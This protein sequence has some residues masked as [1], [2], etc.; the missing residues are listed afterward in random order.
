MTIQRIAHVRRALR[1]KNLDAMVITNEHNRRY[2]SGFTGSAGWLLITPDKLFMITDSR[3]W[4]QSA[5]QAPQFE[6]VK[7]LTRPEQLEKLR[8]TLKTL[9]A[10][11][12][13]FEGDDVSVNQHQQWKEMCAGI[14]LTPL[15]EAVEQLRAVKDEQELA[16][17]RRAIALTDKAYEHIRRWIEP[18]MSEREVAWELEVF[19]RTRGAEGMA[20]DVHVASG[21]GSAEPHH[22]PSERKI[23]MREPIWIDMGAKVDGYCADCT[24]SFTLGEPDAQFKKIYDI[25]LRAQLTAIHALKAGLPGKEADTIARKVIED[26]GFGENYGHGLGHGVGLFIHEK[27]SAGKVSEDT[28]SAGALLTVEPGI[29]I[30]E[31]G[32]VR[33]ED[34]VIIGEQ[35]V[36]NLTTA[37]K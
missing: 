17:I 4:G 3:Y 32:G 33:I 7:H 16:K 31:W 36:E 35:G 23:Q 1:E 19:M 21:P 26:A 13:G 6:L 9:G 25:V 11:K 37:P 12:V 10:Q 18:G 22:A 5:T 24:R 28:L 29:Y 34:V 30:P 8:D 2:L 15:S 20:F 27:P 14:E